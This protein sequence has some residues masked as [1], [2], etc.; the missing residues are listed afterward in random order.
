MRHALISA[1]SAISATCAIATTMALAF[2][3]SA[4][5]DR[6]RSR[7]EGAAS[8]YVVL[9]NE[10]V[11]PGR[12]HAAVKAA[13]GRIVHEN[14]D[15]G[16]ATVVSRN[17]DFTTDAMEHRALEGVAHNRVIG[18]APKG[19]SSTEVET[20]TGT[21]ALVPGRPGKDTEPLAH[22]QWDMKQ[23]HAT[24]EGSYET[25]PGDRRVLV[26]VLD[27][28]IDG[29]HPDIKAN[30]N[31]AL[32]RNFTHDI[33]KDVDG[34][35][36]DGPCEF[37]SCVDPVDWDDNEHGTH[38]ASTI[39]APRNGLGISGVAPNVSL[40]NIRVGQDSGQFY[41]QPTV[42]GLTYAAK[43]GVN[44]VNMSYFVDPWIWSC[45]DNPADSSA[46]RLEQRTIIAATQR[47]LDFAHEHGVTLVAAAGNQLVDYTKP[48]ADNASPNFPSVPG[49]KPHKRT[50]SANCLSMP[51]E[52]EHVIPVSAT[53]PSTRKSYYSSFGDGHVAVAAPGGDKAD[54]PDGRP[55]DRRG[56]WAAY[57]EHIAKLRGQLD[58]DGTPKV[59]SVVR[60]C[61][62]G[63]CAYY[64]SMQGTSMAA[65]HAGGVAALIISR[66]G[67][68]DGRSR[69]A[70]DPWVVERVLR[71]TA[72]ATPCPSPNTVEY[73]W[74]KL[75]DGKWV[76]NTST[77][78]C[79][80]RARRNGFYGEGIVDALRAVQH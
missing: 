4:A 34:R 50:V 62:N 64:Q 31:K 48:H 53:G 47:A 72:T 23:I 9:Y 27:T 29:D 39:A 14:T 74:Y 24:D 33:P 3:A 36:L 20:A 43:I 35:E 40:V 19:R 58:P 12:A 59:P 18:E 10:D 26:G 69:L 76:K 13:G 73:V 56:I 65:P 37:T 66:Y 49:E 67:R 11:S 7:D 5:P 79:E 45:A 28:G 30:F 25:E 68:P 57:P 44:V 71:G 8:E 16:V 63:T 21:G 55:D 75:T 6:S 77:Q 61:K 17:P 32:S 42:D 51:T 46:D 52:G 54:A 60:S 2:P 80:G 1:I 15:V 70:L 38:V 78:T 41:L 22:L